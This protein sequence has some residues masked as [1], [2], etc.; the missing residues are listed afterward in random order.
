MRVGVSGRLGSPT[1]GAWI[2]FKRV[3]EFAA[4][5]VGSASAHGVKLPVGLEIDAN[6]ADPSEGEVSSCRPSRR[7]ATTR[8]IND[9]SHTNNAVRGTEVRIPARRTERM[10]INRAHVGKN[11]CRA[12][13]VIRRTILR[14]GC[15]R[16]AAG[17][18]M[19]ASGPG[20]PHRV[21]YRDVDRVRHKLETISTSRCHIDNRAGSRWHA[22]HGWL[23]VLIENADGRRALCVGR[24][25]APVARFSS[26]Q[27]CDGKYHSQPKN[28]PYCV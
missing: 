27:K 10:L 13:H 26:H 7:R 28:R 23:A 9:T 25:C 12:I 18:A 1:V 6:E 5:C 16:K 4:G 17:D 20:P 15:A 24:T 3:S 8:N 11:S 19:A 22:A 14:I 21:T 2:I